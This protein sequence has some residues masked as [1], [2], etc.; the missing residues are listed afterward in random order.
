MEYKSTYYDKKNDIEY[1]I[2]DY[3][4]LVD[5]LGEN[6]KEYKSKISYVS[7]L[8]AEGHQFLHGFSGIGGIL[9]FKV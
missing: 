2:L 4:S 1:N 8:S 3:D 6:Y 7:D 9:R 5:F